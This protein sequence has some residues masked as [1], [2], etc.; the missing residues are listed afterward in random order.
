[1]PRTPSNQHPAL[2]IF[3]LF[4]TDG[5][6]VGKQI[7]RTLWRTTRNIPKVFPE[8]VLSFLLSKDAVVVSG[9]ACPSAL[10]VEGM[11]IVGVKPGMGL[12]RCG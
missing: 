6:S 1:M 5:S 2:D 3:K 9:T 12:T 4:R 10:L 7:L 11:T 8:T